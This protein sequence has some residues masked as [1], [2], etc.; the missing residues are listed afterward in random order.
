VGH[1]KDGLLVKTE[2]CTFCRLY[3]EDDEAEPGG[4]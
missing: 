4:S 1:F 3:E 2:P